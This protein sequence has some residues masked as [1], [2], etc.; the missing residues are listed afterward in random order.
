MIY[1]IFFTVSTL[2]FKYFS[3][4]SKVFFNY[5]FCNFQYNHIK[6]LKKKNIFTMR[7]KLKLIFV[8]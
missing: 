4:I 6:I 3:K 8:L 1:F 7:T 2:T 5:N